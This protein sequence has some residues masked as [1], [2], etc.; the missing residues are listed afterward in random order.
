MKKVWLSMLNLKTIGLISYSRWSLSSRQSSCTIA[1]D[2][3]DTGLEKKAHIICW[4]GTVVQEGN[5]QIAVALFCYPQ[6]QGKMHSHPGCLP[7]MTR[8]RSVSCQTTMGEASCHFSLLAHLV[9][10]PTQKGEAQWLLP[11]LPSL[12]L[13][14]G[15]G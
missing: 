6:P 2:S 12:A 5:G 1:S 7:L 14:G 11:Q 13:G 8:A 10:R 4:L 3:A 9:L 15:K